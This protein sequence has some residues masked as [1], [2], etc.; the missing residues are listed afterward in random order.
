MNMLQTV[1]V[2]VSNTYVF[3]GPESVFSPT[4]RKTIQGYGGRLFKNLLFSVWLEYKILTR[5]CSENYHQ[6]P[7]TRKSCL[8]HNYVRV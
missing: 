6:E 5:P 2:M 1:Y 8:L 3:I 4:E 7:I